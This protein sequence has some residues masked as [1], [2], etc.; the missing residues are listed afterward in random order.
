MMTAKKEQLKLKTNKKNNTK[1]TY[2]K[3]RSSGKE[4]LTFLSLLY[5]QYSTK[6]G[7]QEVYNF[8]LHCRIQ[9]LR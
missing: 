3:K 6:N 5:K 4:I 1:N 9:T 8:T 2:A 7:K